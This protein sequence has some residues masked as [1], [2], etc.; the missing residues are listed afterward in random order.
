MPGAE[1][2]LPRHACS[3]RK[4]RRKVVVTQ[5]NIGMIFRKQFA[6]DRQ[7]FLEMLAGGFRLALVL[8][9]GRKVIV[10]SRGTSVDAVLRRL[11]VDLE[12]F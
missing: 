7:R 8:E 1:I 5:R 9:V 3:V 10:D 11:G 12:A 2:V 6:K 4:K